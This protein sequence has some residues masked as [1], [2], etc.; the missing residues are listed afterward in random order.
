M[1]G[2]LV[3]DIAARDRL[4]RKLFAK[5]PKFKWWRVLALTGGI[6]ASY[7]I[8]YAHGY[9]DSTERLLAQPAPVVERSA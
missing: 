4:N 1:T 8:A 3:D 2:V 7:V 9:S 6:V 5:A